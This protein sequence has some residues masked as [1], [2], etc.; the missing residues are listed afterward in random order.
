M[1]SQQSYII[2]TRSYKQ[3]RLNK[4]IYD[5]EDSRI[6]DNYNNDAK[7][8]QL[9]RLRFHDRISKY[10]PYFDGDYCNYLEICKRE[11]QLECIPVSSNYNS[12]AYNNA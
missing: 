3:R 1:G 11:Y 8:E 4:Y 2:E 10:D 9:A 12:E 6:I 5:I 7:L